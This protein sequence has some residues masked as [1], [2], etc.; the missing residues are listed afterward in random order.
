MQARAYPI[1]SG[2]IERHRGRIVVVR[3]RL[4]LDVREEI[5]CFALDLHVWA[6]LKDGLFPGL[7]RVLVLRGLVL[8]QAIDQP[9]FP[10]L[11][12]FDRCDV[13]VAALEMV[14]HRGGST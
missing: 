13:A 8:G 2:K 14:Q 7:D 1:V 11:L 10:P 9:L 3:D 6:V 4:G 12:L 5:G